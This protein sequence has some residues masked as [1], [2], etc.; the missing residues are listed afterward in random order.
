[1]TSI[2][3]LLREAGSCGVDRLDAQLL[4]AR[5]LGRTRTWL[6]AHDDDAVPEDLATRLRADIAERARGVPLAYLLGEREFHGLML[7]VTPDV[8][9]PRPD[10]ELLV[11]WALELLTDLLVAVGNPSVADL[12]T[13]SGAIA[14]AVKRACPRA[15]VLATTPPGLRWIWSRSAVTGWLTSA[16]DDSTCC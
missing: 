16:P 6:I 8:L 7:R 12:G 5:R 4:I 11:D 13:G 10:T 15:Q 3:A 9:V 2:A 1:L 14:L